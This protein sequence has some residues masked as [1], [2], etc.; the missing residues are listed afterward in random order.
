MS[1]LPSTS[2][3]RNTGTFVWGGKY[4]ELV[5]DFDGEP[6]QLPGICFSPVGG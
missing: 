6:F 3:V 1:K 2:L 4:L 5:W